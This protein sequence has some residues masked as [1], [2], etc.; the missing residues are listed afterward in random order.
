M[1]ITIA[2]T[3][4]LSAILVAMP[5]PFGLREVRTPD[6]REGRIVNPDSS[7]GW[8]AYAKGHAKTRCGVYFFREKEGLRFVFSRPDSVRRSNGARDTERLALAKSFTA[9]G[10][11]EDTPSAIELGGWKF[12]IRIPEEDTKSMSC[13]KQPPP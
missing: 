5:N 6:P 10:A 4:V 7:G 11:E 8:S 9:Q 12:E 13:L 3:I 2:I 1:K